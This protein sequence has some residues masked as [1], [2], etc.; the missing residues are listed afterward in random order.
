MNFRETEVLAALTRESFYDFVLEF[1]NTIISEPPILNWHVRLMCDELQSMAERVFKM[2]SR[3]HDLIVNV[4]PGTTKSTIC[5][6]MFPAWVWT[7]M[8]SAKFI[9]V[10]YA[11]QVA[12]KDSLK[13][14]DIVKSELYKRCFPD[15][16][17]RED[18]NMKELFSNTRKGFRLSAGI[19]GSITGYHAH[20]LI[21]D[22]PINPEE[23]PIGMASKALRTRLKNICWI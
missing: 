21:V 8:P 23:P 13:T 3:T 1:W 15:V 4:P 20:F 7:R 10:S 2:Q 16:K 9:C 12:L 19:G 14:R 22:D 6:Q 5:S 11:H 17:L 18:E